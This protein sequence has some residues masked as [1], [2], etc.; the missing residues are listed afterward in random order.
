[1]RPFYKFLIYAVLLSMV[2]VSCKKDKEDTRNTTVKVNAFIKDAMNEIY[3]WT[4]HINPTV[5]NNYKQE[6]D[7]MVYFDK[8]LY[9]T[10]D[11]WSFITDDYQGLINSLN[12]RETT[13]GY[14][15]AFGR[16]SNN[17]DNYFAVIQYVYP[18]SPAAEKGLQRSDILL[19]INGNDITANNY[20]QLIYSS[21]ITLTLGV[22]SGGSITSG[23]TLT[24]TSREMNLNPV[25]IDKV[26]TY[27][28]RKIAYLFYTQYIESYT[29]QLDNAIR[30]FKSEGVNDVILDLRY[31]P[32]GYVS[33]ARHLCSALAPSSVVVNQNNIL[34]RNQWNN[35]YQTYWVQQGRREMLE[36]HFDADV[37]T[38]GINMNLGRLFVLTGRGTASASELTITGLKHYMPVRLIGGVTVGKYV[39]S[40][41]FQPKDMNNNDPSI[42][43][44][45]IQP[46]IYEYANAGGTVDFKNGFTPDVPIDEDVFDH[47]TPLGDIHEVLL[48]KA[49]YEITGVVVPPRAKSTRQ[50]EVRP[51]QLMGTISSRYDKFKENAI[52]EQLKV[53]EK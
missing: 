17:P 19:K 15:L 27:E 13:Y 32:G 26:I 22:L 7:P 9:K 11:K 47:T 41:T 45:A 16:F 49:L 12:G 51:F 35:N 3:L 2:T 33:T 53:N 24:M 20:T 48:S 31:N 6:T 10:E 8:L 21:N 23:S 37:V 28:G 46:I 43:N 29:P 25:V 39:A 5:L 50:P 44:W 40:A 34:I 30:R 18:N 14:S 1:M 38:N 36:Q 52:I 4:A 42:A